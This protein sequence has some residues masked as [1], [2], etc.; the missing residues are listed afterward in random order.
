MPISANVTNRPIT[1]SVGETQIDV[2]VAS[3]QV[4]AS[5]SGGFG[6]SGV[7]G[8]SGVVTVS[9]PVTNSGT[10]SAAN[11]GLAVGAGL[12]TAGGA[13]VVSYGTTAGTACQGNDARLSDARTPLSHTHTASQ[14]TDFT[15]AVIAAAPPTT[16]ASLL[17]SGTLASDRLPLAAANTRG[18]VRIGSGISIDGNGVISASSGYTLPTATDSVLGGVKIGSGVSITDGVISVSTAY[19]ATSHSHSASDITSGTLSAS[20]LPTSGV[21][22]GTYT[23]VTVDTYGR[24]TAGSSPSIAYSSLTGLPTLGTA[25][26]A[27]ST[28]FAAASH[29]HGNIT[30]AGAIGSTSGQIV[31]TTTSG[32][33]TTAATIASSA[34]SGLG[35]AATLNVGTTTG[36]VAAGDHTHTQ[37]HDRSHAIT[38]SSD[39]TATAWRV[40]YSDSS[41]VVTEL[42]LGSAG[43]ALISQGA[44]AAPT[45]GAAGSN[46]ASDL[47][48]GTL[49]FARLAAKARSAANLYLWSSFR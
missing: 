10:S 26:A 36:T 28:D 38:S 14:I 1:A 43:Q 32:V 44:S 17:T 45:W 11:I 21:A 19:A 30:N 8:P 35:G 20:L 16:N 33:L 41:G 23:S 42:S 7:Q 40:F 29:T 4:S 25:A 46:S 12:S 5:V 22:A 24:V 47:T 34:V 31:V 48:T 2:S 13:L 9:A 15:T 18:A 39:H 3:P 6:P 27:A 49:T 37:L